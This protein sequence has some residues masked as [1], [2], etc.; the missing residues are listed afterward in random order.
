[1][2]KQRSASKQISAVR[3]LDLRR[4]PAA[5]MRELWDARLCG[6]AWVN[7]ETFSP[8]R[9][10]VLELCCLRH[11][12][13]GVQGS[14]AAQASRAALFPFDVGAFCGLLRRA[15][16]VDPGTCSETSALQA[17][18]LLESVPTAGVRSVAT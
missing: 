10:V 12:S 2:R 11:S 4:W 14:G 5:I 9:S 3:A 16:V 15:L 8:S 13:V 7:R 6:C 1:M 17:F 18:Q